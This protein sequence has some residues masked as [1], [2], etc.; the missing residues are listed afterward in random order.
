M[1]LSCDPSLAVIPVNISIQHI[2]R[3]GGLPTDF[4]ELSLLIIAISQAST[5]GRDLIL[6]VFY[7]GDV[8]LGKQTRV[9]I[10]N[11]STMLVQQ[12]TPINKSGDDIR[13]GVRIILGI[14]ID[15]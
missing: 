2:T 6:D 5:I 15:S 1:F 10:I 4:G 14:G 7:M 9:V 13:L 12:I 11:I 3:G 8:F